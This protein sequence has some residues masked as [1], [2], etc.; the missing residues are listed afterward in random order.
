MLK[1]TGVILQILGF[2]MKKRDFK[3]FQ[4]A[5]DRHGFKQHEFATIAK[6]N[7]NTVNNWANGHTRIPGP[8]WLLLD[9][10]DARPELK[11]FITGLPK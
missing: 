2:I 8:V 6:A 10:L 1:N 5:L 7:A 4:P 3:L 11:M 9:L